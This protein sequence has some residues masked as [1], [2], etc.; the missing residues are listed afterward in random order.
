MGHCG[1]S[2]DELFSNVGVASGM[3]VGAGSSSAIAIFL[4]K[5]WFKNVE[6]KIDRLI[7]KVQNLEVNYARS[8]EKHIAKKQELELVK[9]DVTIL[10][11]KM[12]KVW[13]TISSLVSPRISDILK[14]EDKN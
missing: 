8:D 7:D 10:Q 11:S 12:E 13:E 9:K 3:A 5:R 2:M 4:A 14:N 6:N 1:V